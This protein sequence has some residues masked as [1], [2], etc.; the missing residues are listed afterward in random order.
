MKGREGL[1]S[2]LP[3]TELARRDS[4]LLRKCN[5][6]FS[7]VPVGSLEKLQECFSLRNTHRTQC[8]EAPNAS[9]AMSVSD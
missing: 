6:Y 7:I 9:G 1:G 8:T 4:A 3:S 2:S 5:A